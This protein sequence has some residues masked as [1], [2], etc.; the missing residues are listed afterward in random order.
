VAF[1][2]DVFAR[3]IVGWRVSSSMRTDCPYRFKT[4]QV[5][6]LNFDQGR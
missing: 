4:D 2:I 1:V 5:Y 6:R 3:R